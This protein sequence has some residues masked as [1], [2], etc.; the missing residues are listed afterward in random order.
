MKWED[1]Q[2]ELRLRLREQRGAQ[3]EVARK[4]GVSRAAVGQY[5][6]GDNDIPA[7]HLEVILETLQLELELKKRHSE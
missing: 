3:A 2:Q 1:L 6:A 5:V 4:L 7:S